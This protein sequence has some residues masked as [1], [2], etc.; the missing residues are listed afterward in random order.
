MLGV[1]CHSRICRKEPQLP[2]THNP[3]PREPQSELE[4]R[5]NALKETVTLQVCIPRL[6][7]WAIC[8]VQQESIIEAPV[9]NEDELLAVYEDLLALPQ[10]E[11][12][13]DV[14]I[15]LPI[16]AEGDLFMVETIRDRLANIG[17][18]N[19]EVTANDGFASRLRQRQ[20]VKGSPDSQA[21]SQVDHHSRSDYTADWLNDLVNQLERIVADIEAIRTIANKKE[22]SLAKNHRTEAIPSGLISELEWAAL[23]RHAVSVYSC[24]IPVGTKVCLFL[25]RP[26]SETALLEI[27]SC[28]F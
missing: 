22:F 27:E 28:L 25:D 11:H 21:L 26:G 7:V 24:S 20:N 12:E 23:A 9:Y 17:A 1:C 5:V 19:A 2:D 4:K 16:S 13:S 8:N 15:D 18:E 3:P 10:A 14:D 6:C